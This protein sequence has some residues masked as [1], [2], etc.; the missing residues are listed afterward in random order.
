MTS[1]TLVS[2]VDRAIWHD[3]DFVGEPTWP[4]TRQLAQVFERQ[5]DFDLIHSHADH[6]FFP[7]L[8][9]LDVLAVSTLHA[10]LDLPLY[11]DTLAHYPFAPLISISDAQRTGVADLDLRWLATVH[12][13]LEPSTFTYSEEPGGYLVFLGRMSPEK[14]PEAAIR[15]AREVGLPLRIA[16]K[17]PAQ[18]HHYYEDVLV[19]L[20]KEPG[21]EFLGEVNEQ[22]KAQLL[23]NACALLFPADW[24]EPF[25]LALIEALASGTPV[26]TLKRGS[27]P[28][29]I[30]DGVTGFVCDSVGEMAEACSRLG[31]ISRA[32]CRQRFLD[33]F[34]VDRMVDRYEDVYTE[35]LAQERLPRDVARER[36]PAPPL[37]SVPA[38]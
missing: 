17:I 3:L 20:L 26:V 4:I 34:T 22:Q 19:P 14:G 11:R 32:A 31:D 15:I 38:G 36:R 2:G 30:V 1:A 7:L 18:D 12:H 23:A 29:I 35:A 9:G 8:Y 33:E 6:G 13:G 10:R 21:V 27:I 28:E 5:G 24:P 37:R 16:A 25:G